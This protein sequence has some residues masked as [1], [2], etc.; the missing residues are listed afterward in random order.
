VLRRRGRGRY[1]VNRLR[2]RMKMEGSAR[3]LSRKSATRYTVH[4][5]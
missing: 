2:R 1:A 5:S 4:E 3:R